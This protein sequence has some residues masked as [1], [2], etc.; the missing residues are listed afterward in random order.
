MANYTIKYNKSLCIGAASCS[1]LCPENYSID[2]ENKAVVKNSIISDKEL[3]KNVSA[4]ESCP[5]RAIEIY[6]EKGKK[7]AP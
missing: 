7:I 2:S 4:A 3:K 6:D 1:A 5:T